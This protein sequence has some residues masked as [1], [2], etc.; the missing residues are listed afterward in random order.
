MNPERENQLERE[1]DVALKALPELEAPATLRL[2]VLATLEHRARLPWYRQSWQCWP[3]PLQVAGLVGLAMFFGALCFGGWLAP[4]TAV[5][6]GLRD[7]VAAWAS[8][9]VALWGAANTLLAAVAMVFKQMGAGWMLGCISAVA[10]AW[11]LCLG[12]ST[13]CLRLAFARR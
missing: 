9:T 5:F 11:G 8:Y 1:V 12:L 3:G 10:L 7:Q 13:A 6:A 2:R 4:Q